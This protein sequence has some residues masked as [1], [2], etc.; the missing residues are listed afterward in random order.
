MIIGVTASVALL[1]PSID[2]SLTGFMLAFASTVTSDVRV[3]IFYYCGEL[4]L[5]SLPALVFSEYLTVIRLRSL[6][7]IA[8]F[9]C[10]VL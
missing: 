3:L 10:D 4:I 9:R 6:L 7:I 1:Q 2:A 8:T 5:F